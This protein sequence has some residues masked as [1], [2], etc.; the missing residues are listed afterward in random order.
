MEYQRKCLYCGA[1]FVGHDKRKVY[2]SK[3]C[4]DT[5]LRLRKGIKCN[6]DIKAEKKICVVCGKEFETRRKEQTTCSH[7]CSVEK[8]RRRPRKSGRPK[9]RDK[10][11]A[12]T[13]EEWLK[14]Q[15][16]ISEANAEM[17]R[18]ERRFYLAQH[19]VERECVICGS[20]FYCLDVEKRKT[21]SH[22]CSRRRANKS[23]DKRIPAAQIVDTDISNALLFRRDGGRCWICGGLCDWNDRK[24]S[25]RGRETFGDTYPSIDHVVPV[26]MGGLHSWDNVRLAHL[27]CN[28]E[29]SD[30]LVGFD[31]MPVKIAYREKRTGT[32][33]KKTIQMTL[34]GEIVRVWDSTA[35]IKR[36]MGWSDRHI[37][38]VCRGDGESAYGFKWEYA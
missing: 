19:T 25:K 32:Q 12:H 8:E 3:L 37:Q 9:G 15:R 22:E 14:K 23:K 13:K 2:C 16:Q 28:Q 26:S 38:N 31:Q 29:K 1:D 18:I 33:P 6:P 27:K 24:L 7:E 30:T 21:C 36:E 11:Y 4:A 34:D 20:L 17:K 35:Q 10:R 5:A